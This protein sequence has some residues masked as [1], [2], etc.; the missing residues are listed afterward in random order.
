MATET[1]LTAAPDAGLVE[2]VIEAEDW[3][4][5]LPDLPALADTAAHAALDAAGLESEGFEIALLACDDARITA[6]NTSFRGREAPTNVLSWPA[7]DLPPPSTG[8]LPTAPTAPG[9]LGDVAIALETCRREALAAGRPLKDHVV[10]LILHG[11]LHL[12]GYD[13]ETEADAALMEDVERRQLARMG[14]PDPYDH[15][16]GHA[17]RD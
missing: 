4:Q 12:L 11:C 17:P 3:L 7:Y 10:H 2:V 13:H 9:A 14:I 16:E 6:L 1:L 8:A 5:T 15:G